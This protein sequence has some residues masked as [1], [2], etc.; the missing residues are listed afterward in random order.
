MGAEIE[1]A[2][3]VIDLPDL[4]GRAKLEALGVSVRTL[5]SFEG[6]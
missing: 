5:V 6:H 1:A 2:C 4:G 3:F